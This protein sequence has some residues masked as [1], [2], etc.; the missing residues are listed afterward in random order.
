M[1]LFTVLRIHNGFIADQDPDP[2]FYV[3]ADRTDRDPGEPNQ[4]VSGSETLPIYPC[5][6]K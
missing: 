5:S 4:G 2:A 6:H 3:N 1:L